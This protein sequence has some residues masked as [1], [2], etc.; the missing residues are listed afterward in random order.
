EKKI[1]HRMVEKN[2]GKTK[3]VLADGPP[4][5]NGSIHLG[6]APNKTLKDIIIKYN[7]LR[8]YEAQV[9]PGWD[10]H[11]LL[12]EHKVMKDLADKK[13]VK[14]DA[15]ILALCRAE[16]SKWIEQQRGQFRRLGVLA[17]WEN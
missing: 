1:Y 14:T 4:Y 13:I 15:E 6:A 2:R 11:G 9:I 17:D 10:C 3:F 12:I 8:G 16:A 7:N 5:A